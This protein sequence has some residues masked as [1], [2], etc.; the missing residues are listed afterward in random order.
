[1]KENGQEPGI[2]INF[3][4][5]INDS[6]CTDE[7]IETH[8]WILYSQCDQNIVNRALKLLEHNRKVVAEKIAKVILDSATV[9]L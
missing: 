4:K 2:F 1:M 6:N 5:V 8:F 3:K 9:K 7:M